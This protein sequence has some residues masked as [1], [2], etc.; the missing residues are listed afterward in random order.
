MR[1]NGGLLSSG[2]SAYV[3]NI[4]KQCE[5]TNTYVAIRHEYSGECLIKCRDCG[6]Y[7]EDDHQ[8]KSCKKVTKRFGYLQKNAY[9]YIN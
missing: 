9:I 5:C 4:K 3:K 1:L 7:V 8:K 2:T 6:R